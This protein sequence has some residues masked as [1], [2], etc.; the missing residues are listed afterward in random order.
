MTSI[1]E[2][3]AEARGAIKKVGAAIKGE[4]GI[5]LLLM[6]EHG[7]VA[8]LLNQVANAWGDAM[9]VRTEL[10]PR[11]KA[12]L[13][14]HSRAE[15]EILYPIATRF[16]GT[17][18]IAIHSIEEHEEVKQLLHRLQAMDITTS[19]WMAT[20]LLLKR[21]VEKHV[22]E[23]EDVLLPKL[24]AAMSRDELAGLEHRYRQEKQRQLAL[25]LH[26]DFGAQPHA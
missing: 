26:D 11:I 6:Q 13:L 7:A 16:H 23:E 24:G 5:V 17:R 15:E 21:G 8:S 25:L 20:F 22:A 10:F 12:E 4:R 14:A 2:L 18:D 19:Q 3:R 9:E 1:R